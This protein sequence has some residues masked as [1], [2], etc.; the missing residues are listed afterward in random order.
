MDDDGVV[1]ASSK[2]GPVK[3]KVKIQKINGFSK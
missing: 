3:I 1:E 2:L